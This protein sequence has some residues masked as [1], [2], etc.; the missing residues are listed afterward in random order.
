MF[1]APKQ[2]LIRNGEWRT[3]AIHAELLLDFGDFEFKYAV[4][5]EICPPIWNDNCA[6]NSTCE[7]S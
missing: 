3:W 7:K 1:S 4:D 2:E 5:E 6:V